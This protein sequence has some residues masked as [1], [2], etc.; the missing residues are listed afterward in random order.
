MMADKGHRKTSL[1][2]SAMMLA[3][4]FG[5]ALAAAQGTDSG[6]PAQARV[7]PSVSCYRP[8]TSQ[9]AT[10][11]LIK[12]DGVAE[13]KSLGFAT[14]LDLR[15]PLEG[16]EPEQRAAAAV[17]I[18]YID[19]P[20]AQDIPPEEE[21]KAFARIVEDPG[22]HPLLIHCVSA[23]RVGVMWTLYQVRRGVPFATAVAEGRAIGMK[24]AREHFVRKHL[25]EP[26]CTDVCP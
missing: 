13:L 19:L 2:M 24:P 23:N 26:G 4:C 25:G 8:L 21:L 16:I 22:N 18:R 9:I 12:A 5:A 7:S 3:A 15:D 6:V 17:G 10:G 1:I 20:F 14:I 11:G